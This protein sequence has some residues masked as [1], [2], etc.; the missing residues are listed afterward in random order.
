MPGPVL[1]V[2]PK[3][4]LSVEPGPCTQ[5]LT[6]FDSTKTPS[7]PLDKNTVTEDSKHL[8]L[9]VAGKQNLPPQ[10]VSLVCAFFQDENSQGPK[11]QE[12][13]LTFP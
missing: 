2:E 13:T 7:N 6:E 10:D 12:E 5:D 4:M 1:N 11:T 3:S 9:F 8:P